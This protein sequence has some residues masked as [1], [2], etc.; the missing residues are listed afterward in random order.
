MRIMMLTIPNGYE[1][2]TPSRSIGW[3]ACWSRNG[4]LVHKQFIQADAI[5][6]LRSE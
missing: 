6:A 1:R 5:Q 2:R 4:I 3:R